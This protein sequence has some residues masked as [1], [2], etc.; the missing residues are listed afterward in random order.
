MHLKDLRT[1]LQLRRIARNPWETIRFERHAVDGQLHVVQLAGG[2][3]LYL[4]PGQEDFEAFEEIYLKDR[5][6]TAKPPAG[7]FGVVV[8]IGGH[9]G[10]FAARVS[11]LAARVI[12]YEPQPANFACLARNV[13]ACLNVDAVC[14]A[15]S[16][17]SGPI[18]LYHPQA[19]SQSGRFSCKED[20][21]SELST[22]FDEVVAVSLADL[23][24]THRVDRCSLLKLSVSGAEYD[25]LYNTPKDVL[26][27]IDRIHGEYHDLRSHL[28]GA[29]MQALG[30][31]LR[32]NGFQVE[33]VDKPAGSASGLFFAVRD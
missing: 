33:L 25:I 10:L 27:R 13:A 22:R 18:R 5:Y 29:R 3:Y 1:Y 11:R 19:S 20:V 9:V 30:R 6:R 4:R 31:F 32:S 15:V 14:A 2:P 28:P 21:S 7:G 23:F 8:D 24:A 12:C 26:D 16:S 17:R